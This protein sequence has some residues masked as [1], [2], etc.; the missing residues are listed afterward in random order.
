MAEVERYGE[1]LRRM[2]SRRNDRWL[3]Q[4]V[5]L[6]TAFA[7][8]AGCRFDEARERL[9]RALTT[10]RELHDDGNEP[11]IVGTFS[12]YHRCRGEVDE[13]VGIGRRALVLARE[14][15]HAEWIAST[16]S[17]LGGTLL[18]AGVRDEAV[19]V[20]REGVEA[21]ERSG[22]EMHNLR[23]AGMLV[24]T[25]ARLEPGGAPELLR[26]A[27]AKL[28]TVRVPTGEALLFAWDGTVGIAAAR[29]SRGDAAG[30]LEILDPL[31][32]SCEERAWPEAVVDASLTQGGALAAVGDRDGALAAARRADE[33]SRRHGLALYAW[34]AQAAVA[35]FLA[36]GDASLAADRAS[37]SAAALLD[38][39][40]D[41]S[42]RG[43]LQIE[44]E[45][46]LAGEGGAWA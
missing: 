40:T 28:R 4:F 26:S 38:S 15:A 25:L 43:A 20:L 21:A 1:E 33:W 10:N 3:E 5:D 6:E 37:A 17:Q 14:R 9:E 13:A 2:Y 36:E 19:E 30:A 44:I 39:V 12:P 11:L 23:C 7:S 42:V 16:A 35:S 27:E 32:R 31:V 41:A 34:R 22:A 18:Q 8:I 24:R 46:V 45:R 29:L